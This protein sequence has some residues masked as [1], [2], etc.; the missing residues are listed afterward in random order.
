VP[1]LTKPRKRGCLRCS[2]SKQRPFRLRCDLATVIFIPQRAF[3]ALGFGSSIICLNYLD[4]HVAHC[5]LCNLL[6]RSEH[7]L[8]LC[9][10]LKDRG[11]TGGYSGKHFKFNFSA[12]NTRNASLGFASQVL[13]E[14]TT[15]RSCRDH[16]DE[17]QVPGSIGVELAPMW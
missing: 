11:P 8:N 9:L 6:S 15:P 2:R 12:Q 14:Y 7:E 16:E 4:I 13:S 3:L 17:F 10:F 5:G 1:K